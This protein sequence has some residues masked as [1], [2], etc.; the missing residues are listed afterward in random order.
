MMHA[1]SL[2]R[3]ASAFVGLVG[4]AD[5]ERQSDD[6][7][8]TNPKRQLRRRR[9]TLVA[10]LCATGIG[11]TFVAIAPWLGALLISLFGL[12]VFVDVVLLARRQRQLEERAMTDAFR[13][14]R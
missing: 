10:L 13:S 7:R 4:V 2:S 1:R 5:V 6:P 9:I 14:R 11:A 12:T 3:R 8:S